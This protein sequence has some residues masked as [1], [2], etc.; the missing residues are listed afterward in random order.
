MDAGEPGRNDTIEV[1]ITDSRGTVVY[2]GRIGGNNQAHGNG[3][4]NPPP[5]GF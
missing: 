2:T 1:K 4:S 3:P 5:S